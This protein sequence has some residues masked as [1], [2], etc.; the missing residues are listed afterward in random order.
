MNR[1]LPGISQLLAHQMAP[2]TG[3]RPLAMAAASYANECAHQ[4][5]FRE[6]LHQA[7]DE[8]MERDDRVFLLGEEV[9]HS[10]GPFKVQL[11]ILS[12]F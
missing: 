9:G 1:F 4:L 3:C 2:K 6:A 7:L 11:G 8:E 5:K 12:K 10:E